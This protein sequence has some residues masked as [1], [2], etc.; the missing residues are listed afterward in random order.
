MTH[1]VFISLL[2]IYQIISDRRLHGMLVHP[3]VMSDRW[4]VCP[5]ISE[6]RLLTHYMSSEVKRKSRSHTPLGILRLSVCAPH[7]ILSKHG[8]TR[9][10]G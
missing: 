3:Q 9:C 10:G 8:I 7:Q 4:S 5:S 1:F 6:R 2:Q